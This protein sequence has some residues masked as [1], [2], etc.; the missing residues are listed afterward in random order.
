MVPQS[1]VSA[2]GADMTFQTYF[3]LQPLVRAHALTCLHLVFA[4]QRPAAAAGHV[5]AVAP[6]GC[7]RAALRRFHRWSREDG[8][9]ARAEGAHDVVKLGSRR[10]LIALGVA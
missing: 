9:D 4:G 3:S 7:A 5:P 10:L 1:A 2:A 8:P 6:A